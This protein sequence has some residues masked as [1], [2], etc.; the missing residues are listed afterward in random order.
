MK[1]IFRL[2]NKYLYQHFISICILF[3]AIILSSICTLI[4]PIISGNFVDYL[5]DEKKQQ[6]I[7]FFCLLFAI[8][9]IA[10]ILIGFL[11]N[12]IYTKV[13]LQILY[14]MGQSYIQHMQ[15]MNVLYFSNKNISQITQ[16]ISVDIKSVVDF[17]FDFFSNASINFFKILIP[18]LLVF[19]ISRG[20]CFLMLL[21]M[22]IYLISYIFFKQKLYATSY[23]T[24]KNQNVYFGDLYEQLLK[25]KFIKIYSI[26][27]WFNQTIQKTFDQLLKVTMKFQVIQYIYSGLDT[28]IMFIGQ[29]GVFIIGGNMVIKGRI[30]IGEFT[31]I[32]TYFN[33]GITAVRYFFGLGK[34]KQ[35]T[36][37]AYDRLN[38][39]MEQEEEHFGEM[40]SDTISEVRLHKLGFSINNKIILKDIECK[41]DKGNSYA[42]VGKNGTGKTTL[43]NVLTG[44]YQD[45]T[46]VLK[47]NG[48]SAKRYDMEKLRKKRIALIEQE[49]EMLQDTLY[50]NITLD[51]D[52]PKSL[53]QHLIKEW[54]DDTSFYD[55]DMKIKERSNN[56]S[57]GEKEKIAILRTLV[58]NP[59]IIIMD[60]P[61]ASLDQNSCDRLESL[62]LDNWKDKILIII[63]HDERMIHICDYKIQL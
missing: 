29:L 1:K 17:F 55:L 6:G 31:I 46:G 41:F 54:F 19:R 28:A 13:N 51:L 56:L 59:D 20:M 49:P 45:Y 43:C 39:I 53:V 47:Y 52:I 30:S 34:K 16:Q 42:I 37:V 44:L 33:M 63:T 32:N 61:T 26:M 40:L 2:V 35:E 4:I 38:R 27:D 22:L 57:G 7:I 18:A 58:R 36:L 23:E 48:V 21:L 25:I 3:V 8:V 12:R 60:E 10:N 11:S 24:K 62:I 14:E 5:V 9:S 15:K 50:K